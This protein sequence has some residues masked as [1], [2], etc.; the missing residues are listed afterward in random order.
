MTDAKPSRASPPRLVRAIRRFGT[1]VIVALLGVLSVV[2]VNDAVEVKR[3]A[4]WQARSASWPEANGEIVRTGIQEHRNRK[5]GTSYQPIVVYIYHTPQGPCSGSAIR[6]DHDSE[7]SRSEAQQLIDRYQVGSKVTARY[8]PDR[9]SVSVL[10]VSAP[11]W[12]H[13]RRTGYVPWI[14]AAA[15]ILWIV[16]KLRSVVRRM[17]GKP[18]LAADAGSA[19]SPNI[20]KPK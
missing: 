5:A 4:K 18:L 3:R 10:D 13:V 7:S 9:T 17:Q 20:H 19:S 15:W 6:L 11:D 8:D 2:V 12:E 14:V 16:F 1:V